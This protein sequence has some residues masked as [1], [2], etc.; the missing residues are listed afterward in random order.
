MYRAT[1][2]ST[3][4]QDGGEW[5]ASRLGHFNPGESAPDTHRVGDWVDPRASLDDVDKRKFLTPP[6]L[7]SVRI[8]QT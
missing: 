2:F 5:S 3:T 8:M 1:F 6:G 4:A 7:G